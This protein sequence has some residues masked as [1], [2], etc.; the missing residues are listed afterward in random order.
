YSP[1]AATPRKRQAGDLLLQAD[2]LS[3]LSVVIQQGNHSL[4]RTDCNRPLVA[5]ECAGVDLRIQ[6]DLEQPMSPGSQIPEM[7]VIYAIHAGDT[8]P[9]AA[10]DCEV[11][12]AGGV[13]LYHRLHGLRAT[14]VG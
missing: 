6:A 7:N 13:Q 1:L 10:N 2:A 3:H 14:G 8:F 4:Y 5:R 11:H 9:V 12:L